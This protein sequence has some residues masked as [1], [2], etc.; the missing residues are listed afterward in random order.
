[1]ATPE[2]YETIVNI[3][4]AL[5]LQE[6]VK[7]D[8]IWYLI[9]GDQK[10]GKKF[11]ETPVIIPLPNDPDLDEAP[12]VIATSTD[13]LRI[14]ISRKRIDLFQLVKGKK[15]YVQVNDSLMKSAE[16]VFGLLENLSINRMG[17][18][19]RFFFEDEERM[20]L[21]KKVY[22]KNLPLM[23]EKV[24]LKTALLQYGFSDDFEDVKDVQNH[25]SIRPTELNLADPKRQLLGIEIDRDFNTMKQA[26][27]FVIT[28]NLAK[29]LINAY[30]AEL[31][32]DDFR[33]LLW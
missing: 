15:T 26:E 5:Y 11:V 22:A 25:F 10:L 19:V 16:I 18:V 32:V 9:K 2:K 8:E 3:Q 17:Y 13:R 24:P 14:Q 27:D 20:D 31:R 6:Y 21:L 23:S 4:L 1:M 29:K 28:W 30:E 7:P 12:A 33:K